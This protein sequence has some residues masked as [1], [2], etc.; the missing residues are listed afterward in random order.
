MKQKIIEILK[1][2]ARSTMNMYADFDNV[3]ESQFKSI[4]DEM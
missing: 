1:E 4:A 2:K 3:D